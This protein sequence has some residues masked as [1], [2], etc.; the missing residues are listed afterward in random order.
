MQKNLEAYVKTY[1]GILSKE[2]CAS[3]VSELDKELWVDHGYAI[4]KDAVPANSSNSEFK[5]TTA[6]N[7]PFRDVVMNAIW[8]S[9]RR[10]V[11]DLNFQWFEGWNGFTPVRFNKYEPGRLMRK[12]CDHIHT[13]FD[14]ER[15]G[16][17][18]MTALGI[19]NDAYE[20]GEFLMWDDVEI[21]VSAGDIVVF[22]S[23]FLYPHRVSPVIS[24][25][26]HSFVSW[27]W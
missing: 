10:Y 1:K 24:G 19:L 11:D 23:N 20:G 2:Q 16:V 13:A 27:A 26:R 4:Y 25:V 12:H 3:I 15:K 21:K 22:P 17:P 5:V 14:G 18:T 9:Y 8:M 6:D 7:A